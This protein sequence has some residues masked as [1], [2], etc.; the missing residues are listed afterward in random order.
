MMNTDLK[1]KKVALIINTD[2]YERVSFALALATSYLSLGFEVSIFFTYKGV[3]RL[4]K[5]HEDDDWMKKLPKISEQLEIFRNEG[6]KIYVCP[7]AMAFH[8][9][10][11][12]DLTSNMDGIRG[13]V[14]FL[15]QDAKDAILIYV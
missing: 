12:N 3:L 1:T 5:G 9:L 8:N 6:G 13:L 14:E 7:A 4:R 11:I 2:S 10:T 15:A